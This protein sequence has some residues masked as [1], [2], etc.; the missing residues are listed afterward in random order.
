ME[1]GT[2]HCKLAVVKA[3]L[4][5]GKVRATFTAL[6]GGAG[7]GLDLAAM[8]GVVATLTPRDFY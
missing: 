5:A 4:V 7:L 1:K 6:A 3:L 2:P 8:V